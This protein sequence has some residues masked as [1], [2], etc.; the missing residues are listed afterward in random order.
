MYH[1]ANSRMDHV[2]YKATVVKITEYW[3][4]LKLRL[5]SKHVVFIQVQDETIVS[6]PS[7]KNINNG[8]RLM[9]KESF[10]ADVMLGTVWLKTELP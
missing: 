4:N 2:T 9:K 8:R 1:E 5:I 6:A 7:L 10:T 3:S